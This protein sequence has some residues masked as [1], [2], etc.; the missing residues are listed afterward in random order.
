MIHSVFEIRFN[1]DEAT[2]EDTDDTEKDR[3][4]LYPEASEVRAC[5]S[6]HHFLSVSSVFSVVPLS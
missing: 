3:N 5:L 1:T 2:T 6:L 4:E